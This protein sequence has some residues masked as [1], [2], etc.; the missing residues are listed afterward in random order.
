MP[1]WLL[2]C[3]RRGLTIPQPQCGTVRVEGGAGD[4]ES[5]TSFFKGA[6]Y[7]QFRELRSRKFLK[8]AKAATGADRIQWLNKIKGNASL[9]K[10][11]RATALTLLSMFDTAVSMAQRVEFVIS[12]P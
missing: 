1:T 4:I 8:L 5:R 10:A 6:L 7:L 12:D 2:P 3:S 11:T 9:S